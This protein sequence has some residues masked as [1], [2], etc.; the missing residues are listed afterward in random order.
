MSARIARAPL[1]S[2]VR[3]PDEAVRVRGGTERL[4][5]RPRRGEARHVWLEVTA[6]GASPL[7]RPAVVD[8]DDVAELDTGAVRAAERAPLRDH[9]ASEAGA[10]REHD[11]IVDATAGADPPLGDRRRVRIVVQ[12]DRQLEPARHVIAQ[13][14]VVKREIHH[15]VRPAGHE[16]ERAGYAEADCPHVVAQHLGDRRLELGHERFL[17]VERCHPLVPPEH[18]AFARDDS[19]EDLRPAEVDADRVRGAHRERVP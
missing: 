12:P 2:L 1:V 14:V 4:L 3:E 6:P 9:A 7:T 15:V 13:R 10:E 11:E 16:V 8:D 17:G 5:R 18:L 19:R